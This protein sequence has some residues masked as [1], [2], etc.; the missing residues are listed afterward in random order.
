MTDGLA[1]RM[2][3]RAERAVG[4][5]EER[6]STGPPVHPAAA[7]FPMLPDDELR[8]LAED[9]KANGLMFPIVLGPDG[10]IVDGRN[11][12]AACELAGVEPT[13]TSLD[14]HDP[15]A[16]ILSANARR[17]HMS[18]G[19]LAMAMVEAVVETTTALG[20]TV[21]DDLARM[22]GTS[23]SRIDQAAYVHRHAHPLCLKVIAGALGLDAAKAEAKGGEDAETRREREAAEA[24]AQMA[25]LRA[26]DPK[27]ADAVEEGTVS[28]AEAVDI[29]DKRER[30]RAEA[31]KRHVR[32]MVESTTML[33]TLL[34]RSPEEI[35]GDWLDGVSPQQADGPFAEQIWTPAGL[36]ALGRDLDRLAD[37]MARRMED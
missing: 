36:R 6:V 28:L 16:Y 17:R 3:A 31:Q 32:Y 35:L 37:E 19:A 10:E 11:R 8:E 21:R 1:R 34:Y 20:R 23:S 13:Y 2:S 33:R 12:Y 18:K 25:R 24:V 4:V 9:I 7:V 29:L 27:L 30:E 26:A 22:V 5:M 15:L 14:G